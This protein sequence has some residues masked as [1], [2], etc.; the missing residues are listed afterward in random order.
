MSR[1]SVTFW[2]GKGSGPRLAADGDHATTRKSAVQC[3][4]SHV[5]GGNHGEAWLR[6]GLIRVDGLGRAL[7]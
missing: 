5:Q 6:T 4:P 7:R 2:R 3:V 1:F